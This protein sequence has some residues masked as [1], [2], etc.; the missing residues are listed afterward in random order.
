M[1]HISEENVWTWGNLPD[2]WVTEKVRY[3]TVWINM[4]HFV[5]WGQ[6]YMYIYSDVLYISYIF[7]AACIC[8]YKLN[9]NDTPQK[10][11]V[12]T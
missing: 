12:I 9:K 3:K 11:K 2:I 6:E 4:L 1:L 8:I 5:Y 7:I 10:L